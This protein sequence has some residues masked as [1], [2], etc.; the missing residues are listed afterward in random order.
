MQRVV[1]I[2]P[3]HTDPEAEDRLEEG[4]DLSVSL[5]LLWLC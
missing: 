1:K 5:L 2:K 4:A 3:S